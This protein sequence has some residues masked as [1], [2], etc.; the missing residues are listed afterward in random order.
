ME[1]DS[2]TS[3][4]RSNLS[5][6]TPANGEIRN[7]GTNPHII[8]M[9]IIIPDLVFNVMYHVMAYC[10]KA[11]PNNEKAWLDKKSTIFLFQLFPPAF[12]ASC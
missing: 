7:V 6:H 2:I 3:F 4:F 8:E 5:A 10:T 1:S 12:K 11:D 9:V